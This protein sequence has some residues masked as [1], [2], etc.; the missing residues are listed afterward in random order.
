MGASTSRALPSLALVMVLLSAPGALGAA[1]DELPAGL[2]EALHGP[3]L[4]RA[5][6]AAEQLGLID[7]PPARAALV[8]VLGLGAPPPL[9]LA[10]ITALGQHGDLEA[11]PILRHYASYR[12]V[13]VRV[14][15]LT[16]LG[17]SGGPEAEATILAALSDGDAPVRQAA[18]ELAAQAGLPAAEG[19]LLLLV[20]RGDVAVVA[21]LGRVGG[22]RTVDALTTNGRARGDAKVTPATRAWILGALLL[23]EDFGPDPLRV[24]VVEALGALRT[25]EATA[26]LVRYLAAV[27]VEQQRPSRAAAEAALKGQRR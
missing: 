4:N 20:Q 10:A 11:V 24:R 16:A 18:A 8:R 2:V 27:P 9:L 6:T 14:A 3:D 25:P 26:A 5:L 7:T 1:R 12:S 13:P 15:A 23:R 21:P 17:R 22:A 19:T